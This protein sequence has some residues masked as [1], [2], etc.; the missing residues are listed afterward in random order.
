MMRSWVVFAVLL[1]P[2]ASAAP[3]E[4]YAHTSSFQLFPL[5]TQEPSERFATQPGLPLITQSGCVSDPTG[6]TGFTDRSYHTWYGYSTAGPVEYDVDENGHPRIHPVRG[7]PADIHLNGDAMTLHWYLSMASET[8][9]GIP[10]A[11]DIIVR[12]TLRE[13]DDVSVGNAAFNTGKI[14]AV[15]ESEPVTLSPLADHPQISH[16]MANGQHVYGFHVEMPI[17]VS[18]INATESFNLRVDAFMDNPVCNDPGAE[19]G[20]YL[21]PYNLRIHQSPGLWNR[22]SMDVEAPLNFEQFHAQTIGRDIAIHLSAQSVFGGY[23]VHPGPWIVFD[24]ESPLQ[25]VD[26]AFVVPHGGHLWPRS[27]TYVWDWHNTTAGVYPFSLRIENLQQTANQTLRGELR[28]DAD[29]PLICLDGACLVESGNPDSSIPGVP[30]MTALLALAA[31]ATARR[32]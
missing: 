27:E 2:V 32:R 10:V 8:Q 11:A 29:G 16:H 24:G 6:S 30:A 19:G 13:G 14:I 22:V 18:T 17:L 20:D 21:N 28:L 9:G 31:I 5:T 7:I 3:V 12:G 26:E 15:G 23:D 4:L 25:R 1:L